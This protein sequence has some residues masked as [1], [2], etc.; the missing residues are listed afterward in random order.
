MARSATPTRRSPRRAPAKRRPG[1]G[2]RAPLRPQRAPLLSSD[3]R[4][5][6]GGV[7]A[8]GVGVVLAAVLALPG[9]GSI[10]SRVHDGLFDLFGVGA[11]LCAAGF[12][13]AGVRIL[14][15]RGW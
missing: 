7:A 4:R 9:G 15:R 5:E 2:R 10:A 11:W 3:Q 12:A 14:G 13:I 1:S 8:I 6:L